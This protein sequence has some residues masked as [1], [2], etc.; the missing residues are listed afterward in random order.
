M[1]VGKM[2]RRIERRCDLF[3]VKLIKMYGAATSAM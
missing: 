2:H 1:Q 3:E